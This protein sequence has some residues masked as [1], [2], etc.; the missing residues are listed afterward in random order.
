MRTWPLANIGLSDH[1]EEQRDDHH[2]GGEI[3]DH[4]AAGAAGAATGYEA[5][6]RALGRVATGIGG[7]PRGG[8]PPYGT[9]GRGRHQ[10]S[11]IRSIT[12]SRALPARRLPA[13]S[14]GLGRRAPRKTSR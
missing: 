8:D 1:D 5:Q 9:G 13:I 11:S 4:T 6:W 14:S 2:D 10:P 12:R 3:G 7:D